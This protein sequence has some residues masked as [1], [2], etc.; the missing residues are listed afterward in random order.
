MLQLRS[1]HPG[2]SISAVDLEV[3]THP[4]KRLILEAGVFAT[5]CEPS[6]FD[7]ILGF[8]EHEY[9][10]TVLAAAREN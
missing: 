4:N 7:A 6:W 5:D 2:E 8:S 3:E 10:S 1:L 9:Y